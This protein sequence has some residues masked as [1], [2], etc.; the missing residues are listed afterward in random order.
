MYFHPSKK[1]IRNPAH[2]LTGL[3][4]FCT[5]LGGIFWYLKKP[6]T[7][8]SP[9][10]PTTTAVIPVQHQYE[11]FKEAPQVIV[12]DSHAEETLVEETYKNS[13][14]VNIFKN[15]ELPKIVLI[16]ERSNKNIKVP[17]T[18]LKKHKEALSIKTS[19]DLKKAEKI[20]KK[21]PYLILQ[22][23]KKSLKLLVPWI[24]K[25][26][27]KATFVRLDHLRSKGQKIDSKKIE[28]IPDRLV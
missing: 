7:T 12:E 4:V 8:P 11:D 1:R 3:I 13:D 5:L 14:L 24:K 6:E 2:I 20:L 23:P 26:H 22:I 25:M 16:L 9:P 18:L 10:P 15:T 28:K 21:S 17:V 27:T 19:K